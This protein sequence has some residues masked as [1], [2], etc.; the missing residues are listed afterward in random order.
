MK[1]NSS[2]KLHFVA[3]GGT[4]RNLAKVPLETRKKL[5]KVWTEPRIGLRSESATY[6]FVNYLDETDL[7]SDS[8]NGNKAGWRK[9][10]I[11]DYIYLDIVVALRKFNVKAEQI[12][13]V[14]EV[15]SQPY[16]GDNDAEDGRS[17]WLDIMICVSAG[18]EIE[19]II[20]EEL[21]MVFCDPLSA[22][23]FATSSTK[24]ML[25]VSISKIMNKFRKA[26]NLEEIKVKKSFGDIGLF[27]SKSEINA[28]LDIRSMSEKDVLTLVKKKKGLLSTLESNADI[29]E[30]T[31]EKI[32]SI[33]P[34]EY[35]SISAIKR[36]KEVVNLKTSTTNLYED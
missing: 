17:D 16:N 22:A 6:R 8:R 25:R 15:F 35:A 23:I 11:R 7:L 18:D 10:S 31:A 5:A 14:F 26:N 4:A 27:L 13:P 19:L 30:D 9:F 36:D 29:D 21:G 1:D 33:I 2:Q 12:R 28:I 32:N 34:E 3:M 24:G 20:D